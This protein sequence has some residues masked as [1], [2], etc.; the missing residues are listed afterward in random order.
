MPEGYP[1]DTVLIAI[2]NLTGRRIE[3]VQ[4]LRDNRVVE[5][6][7]AAGLGLALLPRFTTRP[8]PGVVTRPLVGVG[9]VRHIVALSRRDIA[10]RLSVVTVLDHLA[11][12][13]SGLST[14]TDAG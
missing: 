7:V 11:D 10:E 1:F 3:R 8:G 14:R 5:A 2:E 13:G 12:I 6:L 9:A 4:Q